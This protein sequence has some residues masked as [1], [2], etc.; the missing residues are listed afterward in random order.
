M[1]A[2]AAMGHCQLY[3]SLTQLNSKLRKPLASNFVSDCTC[4]EAEQSSTTC[5]TRTIPTDAWMS[6]R[7]NAGCRPE[8]LNNGLGSTQYQPVVA[9]AQDKLI[10]LGVDDYGYCLEP[11]KKY[12][13]NLLLVVHGGGTRTPTPRQAQM[14]EQSRNMSNQYA[15]LL[16][17]AVQ[18]T[19]FSSKR[20][21]VWCLKKQKL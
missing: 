11:T 17:P 7:E 21:R 18:N 19:L 1:D 12:E 14:S 13:T 3:V 20:S 9:H 15:Q 10:G 5:S 2:Q 4:L 16:P 8:I 6:R